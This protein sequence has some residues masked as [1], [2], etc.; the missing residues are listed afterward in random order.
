MRTH[1]EILYDALNA[2]QAIHSAFGQQNLLSTATDDERRA[3][4]ERVI[5]AY[6]TYG[7]PLLDETTAD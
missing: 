3:A 4:L 1:S 6:N 2:L 7:V 5:D